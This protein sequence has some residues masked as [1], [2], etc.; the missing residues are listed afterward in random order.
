MIK[1]KCIN[2]ELIDYLIGFYFLH[3]TI[4]LL[5]FFCIFSSLGY[6]LIPFFIYRI[7]TY[8]P[9]NKVIKN[10]NKNNL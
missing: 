6:I 1:I 10:K 8:T 5:I 9:D 3:H 4:Y 7:G 2:I